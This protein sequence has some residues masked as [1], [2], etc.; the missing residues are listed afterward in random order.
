MPL[1]A[2]Y[3]DLLESMGYHMNAFWFNLRKTN[4]ANESWLIY[5]SKDENFRKVATR[6]VVTLILTV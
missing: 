1:H 6:P 4:A 2:N 3:Y 5:F